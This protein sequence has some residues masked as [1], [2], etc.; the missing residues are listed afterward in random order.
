MING[1]TSSDLNTCIEYLKQENQTMETAD[2]SYSLEDYLDSPDAESCIKISDSTLKNAD[3]NFLKNNVDKLTNFGISTEKIN[4]LIGENTQK[5]ENNKEKV[6]KDTTKNVSVNNLSSAITQNK[7]MKA[8]NKKIANKIQKQNEKNA[9]QRAKM[10]ADLEKSQKEHQNLENIYET[11]KNNSI[12][13]EGLKE[14]QATENANKYQNS[15]IGK[16][17]KANATKTEKYQKIENDTNDIQRTNAASQCFKIDSNEHFSSIKGNI[18]FV[19][20]NFDNSTGYTLAGNHMNTQGVEIMQESVSHNDQGIS[21]ANKGMKMMNS[22][23]NE[24]QMLEAEYIYTSAME[25]VNDSFQT[26]A[27]GQDITLGATKFYKASNNNINIGNRHITKMSFS[28]NSINSNNNDLS[29]KI[30]ELQSKEV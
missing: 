20:N 28:L 15:M 9:T 5:S 18:K 21:L 26:M 23:T 25:I 13:Q 2:L 27:G 1:I 8:K 6:K 7:K 12:I 14:K 24:T 30:Q 19:S 17:D 11:L 22:A 4:E 3:K 10:K 29:T 16:M